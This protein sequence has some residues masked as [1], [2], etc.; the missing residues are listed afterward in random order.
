MVWIIIVIGLILGVI[1]GIFIVA[2]CIA[3]NKGD[4]QLKAAYDERQS[5]LHANATRQ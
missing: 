2:I 5:M 4:K 3:A 1:F